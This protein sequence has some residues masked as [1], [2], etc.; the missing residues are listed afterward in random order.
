MDRQLQQRCLT[1]AMKSDGSNIFILHGF[2]ITTA[3]CKRYQFS[4]S[5]MHLLHTCC[6][7]VAGSPCFGSQ[8]ARLLQTCFVWLISSMR[9]ASPVGLAISML[10]YRRCHLGSGWAQLL[11]F[12]I[13]HLSPCCKKLTFRKRRQTALLAFWLLSCSSKNIN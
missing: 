13:T 5:S 1:V 12:W 4:D 7:V 11:T 8:R 2:E 3:V 10:P 9:L 6:G